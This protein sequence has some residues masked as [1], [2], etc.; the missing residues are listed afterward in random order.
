MDVNRHDPGKF[1]W[2]ELATTN[3]AAAKT[4]YSKL[5]GWTANDLPLGPDAAYS[6]M[7]L[8]GRDAAAMYQVTA[9]QREQGVRPH[10]LPYICVESSDET[11]AAIKA[12]GGT[13]KA[14]PFDVP[15]IGRMAAAYDPTGAYFAIWQPREHIGIGI[16]DEPNA[17]CWAELATRDRASAEAFYTRAFNWDAVTKTSGPMPYTEFYL[18]GRVDEKAAVGGMMD[19]PP[20]LDHIPAH[21]AVYFAVENCDATA[22]RARILG[23]EVLVVPEE[24]PGV[25]RFAVLADPQGAV[26]SIIR[27]NA[28]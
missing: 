4:F 22:A 10:W 24:I 7:Q 13:L 19:M 11:A 2:A 16:R 28:V 18:R 14:E 12:A 3:H 9:K 23:G 6:I 8:R 20:G 1:C 17:F 25:G 26:F 15:S 5:F 27:L 21:W